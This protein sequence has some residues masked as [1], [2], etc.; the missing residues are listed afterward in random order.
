MYI[1]SYCA[2]FFHLCVQCSGHEGQCK[3]MSSSFFIKG[4]LYNV[5]YSTDHELI[6]STLNLA[7][8]TMPNRV[9]SPKTHT[10]GLTNRG[11]WPASAVCVCAY[12]PRNCRNLVLG[13][14]FIYFIRKFQPPKIPCYT[15]SQQGLSLAAVLDIPHIYMYTYSTHQSVW[16]LVYV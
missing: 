10:H 7:S 14:N 3:L 8:V 12:T 15:E 11:V 2:L 16:L 6:D 9:V 4:R 13:Q 1:Y 5:M